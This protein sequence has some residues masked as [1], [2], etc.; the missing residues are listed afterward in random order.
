MGCSL[1]LG[2]GELR[3]LQESSVPQQ[4]DLEES[5]LCCKGPTGRVRGSEMKLRAERLTVEL[6]T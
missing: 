6:V 5:R 2:C 3:S 4:P 1:N